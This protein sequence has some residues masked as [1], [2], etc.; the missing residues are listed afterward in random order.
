M[1]VLLTLIVVAVLGA[2]VP[3]SV[4]AQETVGRT[5]RAVDGNGNG[6]NRTNENVPDGPGL[7]FQTVTYPRS[8]WQQRQQD[9]V[10]WCRLGAMEPSWCL[11]HGYKTRGF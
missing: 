6:G 2:A 3:A 5:G 8:Y 9:Y 7:T 1:K 11:A 4:L 10:D